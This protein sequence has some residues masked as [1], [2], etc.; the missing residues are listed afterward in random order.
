MGLKGWLKINS[1]FLC[2]KYPFVSKP[3]ADYSTA[4]MAVAVA[5]E[6]AL[7]L[8]ICASA[9]CNGKYGMWLGCFIAYALHLVI[10]IFQCAVIRRYIPSAITSFICLPISIYIIFKSIELIKISTLEIAAFTLIGILVVGI[11][12]A[13]AQ[14]MIGI[15]TRRIRKRKQKKIDLQ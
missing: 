8:A 15:V 1:A 10:H 11:N 13:V 5:E 12:L 4:G 2:E 7:C 9:Y 3:F 14:R 6:L